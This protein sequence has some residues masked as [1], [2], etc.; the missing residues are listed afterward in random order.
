MS[1]LLPLNPGQMHGLPI[2]VMFLF[3]FVSVS[4]SVSVSV[5]VSGKAGWKVFGEMFT[6]G[7]RVLNGTAFHSGHMPFGSFICLYLH[8]IIG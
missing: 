4:I 7:T 1:F 5:S 2:R 3:L 8:T 6:T